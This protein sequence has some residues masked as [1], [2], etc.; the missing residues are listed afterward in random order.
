MGLDVLNPTRFRLN[1]DFSV[2]I[3]NY[4]RLSHDLAPVID[5]FLAIEA[6]GWI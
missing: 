6:R 5:G 4:R 3:V 1:T 2:Q